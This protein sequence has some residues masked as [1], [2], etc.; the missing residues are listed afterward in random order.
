MNNCIWC[1]VKC[2]ILLSTSSEASPT[3]EMAHR[4][5]LAHRL[6]G[7][8]AIGQSKHARASSALPGARGVKRSTRV[9]VA[10]PNLNCEPEQALTAGP[11]CQA[12][13]PTN[14]AAAS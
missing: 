6:T 5:T 3:P 8:A 1:K 13:Q 12:L 2:F 7:G 11:R 14:M 9:G 4:E 10:R